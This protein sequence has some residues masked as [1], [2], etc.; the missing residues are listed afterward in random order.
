MLAFSLLGLF[1]APFAPGAFGHGIGMDQAP[2]V[3]FGGMDVT[4]MT[5]LTPTDIT[6]GEVDDANM[7]I[8]FF[9]TETDADFNAVTYRVE[10]Y[11]SDDLLARK[12]FYAD[13]G[14]LD[15]EVR[16]VFSCPATNLWECT[17]YYGEVHPISGGLF[18]RGEGRPVIQGPIFDKGGLY[19]IRVVIEGAKSPKTLVAEPLSF[20]TFVSVAQEHD[21]LIQTAQA[22][23]VPVIVKTYYDDITRLDYSDSDDSMTFEMPFDWDPEYISLVQV[24]HEEIRVPKSFEPYAAGTTFK[25]YVNGVEVDDRVLLLDPYS[26][27]DTN[28]VHFLVAGSELERINGVLG[29]S[30]HGSDRMT[31]KLVPHSES[32]K[33]T[34]EFYLVDPDTGDRAGSTAAI[35]WDSGYGATDEIPFSFAFFDESGGLLKDVRYAYYLVDGG[36]NILRSA[37]DDADALGIDAPEGIDV[38]KMVIP[39]QETHR[40]D[41][42]ILGQG[43]GFDPSYAGA[44]SAVIEV[45]PAAGA[46]GAPRDQQQQQERPQQQPPAGGDG[47]VIPSWV[48]G[49]AGMWAGG[50]IDDSAFAS[51]IGYLVREGV[52]VVPEAGPAE[53]GADGA[54][55]KVPS[56]LK[57]NAKFWSEGQIGDREFAAALQWL[58]S[59]GIV[60][61]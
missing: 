17:D 10:I 30:N 34:A 41:V 11:R 55:M 53:G 38:Q 48:K 3:S 6:V 46:A 5:Q 14:P 7:Q 56:W 54:G 23:E 45:G 21:F 27:D 32:V 4:V 58:I 61:V 1:A 24:V 37:G 44:G 22:Q 49:N 43:P 29:E 57:N 2:P 16:P 52:I 15:V 50:Q 18:A 39:S 12:L 33:N 40:I 8:R 42:Y 28:I 19:N 31:F 59:N 25:G 35:S 13:D 36:G 26:Y 20:E 51:G 60:A 47:V 9:D